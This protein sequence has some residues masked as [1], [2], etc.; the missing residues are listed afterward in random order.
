MRRGGA[1]RQGGGARRETLPLPTG[2]GIAFDAET[3]FVGSDV[4]FGGSPARLLRLNAAGVRALEELRDGPVGSP[5]SGR[6][7]RRLTD[8]GMAHP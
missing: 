6:L 7:A 3:L 4:L 2:F 8:T 1:V 5:E